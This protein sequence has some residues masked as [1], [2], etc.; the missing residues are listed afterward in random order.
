MPSY[1]SSVKA[2]RSLAMIA[3]ADCLPEQRNIVKYVLDFI[4]IKQLEKAVLSIRYGNRALSLV[5]F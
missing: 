5:L 1:L 3:K 2:Y 4:L